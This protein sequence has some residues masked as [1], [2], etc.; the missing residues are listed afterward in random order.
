MAKK[1]EPG[2]TEAR[3]ET[4]AAATTLSS[5][6]MTEAPPVFRK[7]QGDPTVEDPE[8]VKAQRAS[9]KRAAALAVKVQDLDVPDAMKTYMVVKG[10]SDEEI[11]RMA[12]DWKAGKVVTH[13]TT[14]WGEPK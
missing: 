3:G 14:S 8:A 11:D 1:K 4:A 2:E 13:G 12:E 9:A 6:D 10:L 7:L 5:K